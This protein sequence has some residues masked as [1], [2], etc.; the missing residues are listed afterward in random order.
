ML[1]A[2]EDWAP[3]IKVVVILVVAIVLTIVAR[4]LLT[5][6]ATALVARFGTVSTDPVRE[7]DRVRTLSAVTPERD[8]RPDLGDRPAGDPPGR[9]QR[10]QL[11]RAGHHPPRAAP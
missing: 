8:D 5:R 7:A 4:R 9:Q 6:R 11:V 3:A 10:D 1:A 2:V